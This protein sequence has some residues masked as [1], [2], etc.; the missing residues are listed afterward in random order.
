[1]FDLQVNGFQGKKFSCN[2]W[3]QPKKEDIENLNSFLYK[4]S[5]NKY[6]A[7][8][9]TD[10]FEAMS[11]NLKIIQKAQND[12]LVG[13]HIEGGL[14][15]RLGVH[16]EKFAKEFDLKKIKELV[17]N[18]KGLIKLWTFCPS[19]DKD[20]NITKFLQDSNIKVSYGHSNCDYET[21]WNAF[22]NYSVDLVTHFGN[23]MFVFD[24]FKQRNTSKDILKALDTIEP[25]HAGIGLAAYRHPKVKLMAIAG[26]KANADL[27][28][29][30]KLLKKLFD[31]KKKQMILVS[32]L[33]H[34]DGVNEPK[35]LVGGL[36]SLKTHCKNALDAG[37]SKEEV[38]HATETLP[39]QI[40]S[41]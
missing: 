5:V 22:E 11:T 3:E 6:L 40:I 30:P 27:H 20:G 9:I 4:E 8:L 38:E 14:I 15:S 10:S 23:A 18:F 24:G 2:F 1:M 26:S 13:A 41:F 16:N 35:V 19:L 33:V 25:D 39:S 12:M 21:A 29:D 32:D 37:V 36:T 34:Y 28:L 31:H 7:T 17:K